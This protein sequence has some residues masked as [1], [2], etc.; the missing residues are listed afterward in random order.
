MDGF[1]MGT[2]ED[3]EE[4][5]KAYQKR[6]N[7]I[8]DQYGADITKLEKD[9]EKT[10][11]KIL[12]ANKFLE[13]LLKI[14]LTIIII[15]IIVCIILLLFAWK[16]AKYRTKEELELKNSGVDNSKFL[17]YYIKNEEE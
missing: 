7:E 14:L 10:K 8:K 13:K 12:K 5:E 17:E 11:K 9:S 1:D 15:G 2:K 3:W 4:I 16:Y 6:E